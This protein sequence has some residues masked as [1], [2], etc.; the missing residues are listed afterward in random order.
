M[1]GLRSSKLFIIDIEPDPRAPKLVKTIEK[2][3]LSEKAGYSRPHTVHC[4][5]NGVFMTCLGGA[6]GDGDGPGGIALLDHDSFDVVRRW[7]TDR[8]PQ[9]FHYDAW[10]H[11]NKNTL[12]S[13]EWV[14]PSMF[15]SGV[16]PE[17]L[18][19]NKY[20]H[21]MHFW[22]L[23]TGEH[24]QR[25][26]LGEDQQMVLEV[27]PSH[28]PE[29]TWGFVGVVISTADL[30]GS[31]FYWH[32]DG[33]EWKAKKV[34]TIPAKPVDDIT[35]L[36]PLLKPFNA[37]PPIITDIDLSV[38]DKYLYVSCWANGEL[39]QYNVSNPS[40]PVE[41]GSGSVASS[42]QF[43]TQRGQISRSMVGRR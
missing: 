24:R 30:S 18:L 17:L 37:V 9:H 27:R 12:I 2:N 41:V 42:I 23:A 8:G 14:S 25:V 32:L 3:E 26:D 28:D 33:E 29:A 7:E 4:G 13:S 16:V 31:I 5:P 36:P 35:L 21:C 10:W 6:E 22:D 15:E 19:Q 43:R 40:S 34:I 1:P 39:K 20:G 11:L 38:D